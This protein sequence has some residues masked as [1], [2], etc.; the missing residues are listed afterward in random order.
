MELKKCNHCNKTIYTPYHI[1]DITEDKKINSYD[2]CAKCGEKM[3]NQKNLTAVDLELQEISQIET[4]DDLLN[5]VLTGKIKGK[6]EK[7]P[8][9]KCGLTH[10]VFKKKGRIGCSECYKHFYEELK[11]FFQSYHKSDLHIG[12]KPQHDFKEDG[13]EKIKL[14]KLK[15]AKAIELE[16]YEEAKEIKAELNEIQNSPS[17]FLDQ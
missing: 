14:L 10:K 12:K 9:P 2:L 1:T 16:K 11:T 6:A 3:Y 13:K 17:S 5:F 8:C 4:F 7:A 15:M